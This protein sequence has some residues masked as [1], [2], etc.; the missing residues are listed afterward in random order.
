MKIGEHYDIARVTPS[1][2]RHL[3]RSCSV[4]EEQVIGMLTD[5]ARVLPDV[6][7]AAHARAR[8]DGLSKQ[9]LVPLADH[10]IAHAGA[11]LESITAVRSSSRVRRKPQPR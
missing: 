6:V 2:W 5:M 4:D 8:A 9:A 11:R 1:D 10:L 3:A 7:S